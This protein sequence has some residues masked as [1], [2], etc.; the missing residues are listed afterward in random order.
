MAAANPDLAPAA[1]PAGTAAALADLIAWPEARDPPPLWLLPAQTISF[2]RGLAALRC[3]GGV[4]L[5]DPVGSGK[6]Y[7]ALAIAVRCADAD[8]IQVIVPAVLE[9]QWRRVAARLD[10]VI[11]VTSHERVSR[12][13]PI[14]PRGPVIIDECHRFRNPDTR[15]YRL[16]APALIGRPTIL[17][18]ATPV[19]NDLRDLANQLLLAVRA[20]ALRFHGL[21]S[22]ALLDRGAPPVAIGRLVVRAEPDRGAAPDREDRRLTWAT[23]DDPFFLRALEG[24]DRLRLSSDRGVASLV[25]TSLYRA[26]GSSPAAILA[27]IRRYRVLLEHAALAKRAGKR[28]SRRELWRAAGVIPE[29]LVMWELLEPSDGTCDLSVSDRPRLAALE[30]LLR[31]WAEQGDQKT[32]LLR[33]LL[34]DR[35]PTL[36]FTGAIETVTYLRHRLALPGT[37]WITG[38]R[39]GFGSLKA[40]RQTVLES[41]APNGRPDVDWP[42]APWLLLA[43]DVAA[44]GLDLQRVSRIIH[45]DLPWTSVR[46][47]QRDGR[48]LRRGSSHRAVA[49]VRFDSPAELESRL[50]L[51]T[52]L[53]RKARLPA[54]I[55]LSTEVDRGW[56]VSDRLRAGFD[57]VV[58]EHGWIV[59]DAGKRFSIA[60]IWIEVGPERF[61]L[62][63]SDPGN[64]QWTDDPTLAEALLGA[65]AHRPATLWDRSRLD[66]A[67][68]S[69]QA[70]LRQ[71]L[72]AL[73]GTALFESDQAASRAIRRVRDLALLASRRRSGSELARYDRS[74]RFLQRGHTAGEEAVVQGV[75]SGDS[76]SV[77]R[78]A[79]LG[80]RFDSPPRVSV[81]ALILGAGP[82]PN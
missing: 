41:F 40:G 33:A 73:H 65:A 56:R 16:L 51:A 35:T 47:E 7:L 55:G 28:V 81:V 80:D 1:T 48:A 44:E 53:E 32:E 27:S 11:A 25:R 77:N 8:P 3:Y 37:A 67:L 74:L 29:Q 69:L 22:L 57:G 62:V 38:N 15:R 75:A 18:S 82:R 26:L 43:T 2:R 21:R 14:G 70:T 58:R 13:G 52:R 72:T 19:V 31:R 60:G 78:A 36:V 63:L 12:G 66:A 10:I 49:V 79:D 24:L 6:T 34:Y 42:G 30:P 46:L 23:T 17:V 5:A 39:A 59:V 76:D 68:G 64:G 54:R 50:G 9:A 71:R 61:G 20:D 45:F 4:L